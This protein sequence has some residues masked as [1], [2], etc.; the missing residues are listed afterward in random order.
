M[1]N[2]DLSVSDETTAEERTAVLRKGEGGPR[3]AS[4]PL[5]LECA[6]LSAPRTSTT[7]PA[8][9]RFER[10]AFPFPLR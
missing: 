4:Q 2:D 10:A 7:G 3:A 8:L 5:G 9:V 6:A 1:T